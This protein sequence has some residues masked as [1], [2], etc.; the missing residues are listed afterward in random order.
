MAAKEPNEPKHPSKTEPD[1]DT[2]EEDTID[3]RYVTSIKE[4]QYS[5]IKG[6]A[7]ASKIFLSHSCAQA[8]PTFE[9]GPAC[10]TRIKKLVSCT[11]DFQGIRF[12][13]YNCEI[14]KLSQVFT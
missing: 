2:S 3:P 12:F 9:K 10:R 14:Q 6:S 4:R 8:N 5:T 11:E 1:S 7:I 13:F